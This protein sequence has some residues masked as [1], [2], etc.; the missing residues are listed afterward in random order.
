M[1][2][3]YRELNS[4]KEVNQPSIRL[5]EPAVTAFRFSLPR[6]YSDSHYELQK[7][8]KQVSLLCFW[9]TEREQSKHAVIHL[10]K[11]YRNSNIGNFN[12]IAINCDPFKPRAT[13]NSQDLTGITML[14]DQEGL[15]KEIYKVQKLPSTFLIDKQGMIRDEKVGGPLN[16]WA[17]LRQ[18][19]E[20]LTKE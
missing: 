13:F 18:R 12:V 11:W 19:I 8:C 10:D 9:S 2:N 17:R 1:L 7:D 3:T 16:D 20:A 5:L 15:T 6:L 4:I 14:W